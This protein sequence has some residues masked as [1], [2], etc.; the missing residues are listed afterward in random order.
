MKA[1]QLVKLIDTLVEKKL[2]AKVKQLIREEVSSQVNKVMGQ[3]LVEMVSRGKTAP[4]QEAPLET[5]INTRNPKLN[6]VLAETARYSRPIPRATQLAEIMGGDFDKIG[7][8]VEEAYN[9]IAGSAAPAAPRV[10][11]PDG[12]NIGFLKSMVSEGTTTGQVQSVLG[13][14][15]VPDVLK[16]VFFG[17]ARDVV[18]KM[19]EQKKNGTQGLISPAGLFSG[20]G[21]GY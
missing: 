17:K 3:M 4:A 9:G 6:Q 16:G 10:V 8:E 7:A 20:Q 1:E 21:E 2:N 19:N 18:R 11:E 14:D 15:A 12:T 13:T 5:P